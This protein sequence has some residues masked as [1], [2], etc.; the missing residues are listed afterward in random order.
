MV[1]GSKKLR[2]LH[3][4]RTTGRQSTAVSNRQAQSVQGDEMNKSNIL[5]I[6]TILTAASAIGAS[7]ADDFFCIPYG[8]F[9]IL[10]G[11]GISLC[12]GDK[13]ITLATQNLDEA[14]TIMA[15]EP[16][17]WHLVAVHG[18]NVVAY[19][20]ADKAMDAM[21]DEAVGYAVV[22]E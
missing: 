20:S 12:G 5:L 10:I 17:R 11:Y 1:A 21:T 15:N 16:G 4:Y 3:G 22:G 8:F 19:R 9:L 6:L 13:T 7:I 18:H 2:I 14:C